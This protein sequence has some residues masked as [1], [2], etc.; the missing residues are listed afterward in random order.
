MDAAEYKN[1]VLPLIFLK[2]VSDSFIAQQK[3]VLGMI[4]DQINIDF[5][6]E[7]QYREEALEDKDYYKQDVVF[8]VPRNARWE[9]LRNNAKQSD[10]GQRIDK[11]LIAIESANPSLKDK[12]DKRFG[13]AQLEP[14]TLGELIDLFST[15]E[16]DNKEKSRDIFGEVF[17]YF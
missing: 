6:L 1:L 12:L 14:G 10:I 4:S 2:F 17:E 13:A 8:W 9:E 16:L 5:Y 7:P 15:K 11:A 3:K